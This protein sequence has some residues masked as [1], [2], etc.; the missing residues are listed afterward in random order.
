[1]SLGGVYGI[2][3]ST[4]GSLQERYCDDTSRQGSQGV[5]IRGSLS[6]LLFWGK[7]RLQTGPSA[8]VSSS[9]TAEVL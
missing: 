2:H 3:G 1:M 7:N 9:I 5:T 4:P 6:D 8:A